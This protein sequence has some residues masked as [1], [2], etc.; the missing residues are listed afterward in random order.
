MSAFAAGMIF[1]LSAVLSSIRL[2]NEVSCALCLSFHAV[3][4]GLTPLFTRRSPRDES[5][6]SGTDELRTCFRVFVSVRRFSSNFIDARL[7][8]GVSGGAGCCG[9]GESV[10]CADRGCCVCLGVVCVGRPFCHLNESSIFLPVERCRRPWR[11]AGVYAGEAVRF[12][13]RAIRHWIA[14]P[15]AERCDPLL[16]RSR[17]HTRLA[18]ALQ[19]KRCICVR[20]SSAGLFSIRKVCEASAIRVRLLP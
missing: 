16:R 9:A 12:S 17:A 10:R 6:Q 3:L 7:S 8:R 11:L 13:P 14:E 2:R 20:D 4:S 5:S 15:L 18:A 19:G 1:V